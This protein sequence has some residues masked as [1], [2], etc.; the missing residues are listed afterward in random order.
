[1][2]KLLSTF[3]SLAAFGF[4]LF[5][6][7]QTAQTQIAAPK[8]GAED[9]AKFIKTFPSLVKD[10]KEFE[11]LASVEGSAGA[12]PMGQISTALKAQGKLD[13]FAK[14]N[15]YKDASDILTQA[16][17]ISS[18]YA[19]LKYDA[20][21]ETMK[22]QMASMPPEAQALIKAQTQTLDKQMAQS[23]KLVS[24]E[25]LSAVKAK[26]PEIDAIF[27]RLSSKK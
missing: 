20:A 14:A 4:A 21:L 16:G 17:A 19:S 24:K 22:A 27:Q 1:M 2:K 11:K 23:R 7:A 3:M 8:L 10:F 6:S 13:A 25:T 15:G 26:L 9:V 12:N 5:A 18:A